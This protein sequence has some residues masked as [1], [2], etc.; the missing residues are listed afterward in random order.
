MR[1][2]SKKIALLLALVMLAAVIPTAMADDGN[3]GI[4]PAS[5]QPL[6]EVGTYNDPIVIDLTDLNPDALDQVPMKT[7]LEK[8]NE[9][10]EKESKD[11]VDTENSTVAWTKCYYQYN[12]NGKDDYKL[13]D[14]EGNL[15]LDV[16]YTVYELEWPD[17]DYAVTEDD[18]ADLR[19]FYTNDPA[20]VYLLLIVG[21]K[22]NDQL[23]AESKRF[24]VKALLPQEN[25]ILDFTATN[26]DDGANN[27]PIKIIDVYSH[28][29]YYDKDTD[30]D[31][32]HVEIPLSFKGESVSLKMDFKASLEDKYKDLEIYPGIFKTKEEAASAVKLDDNIYTDKFDG[33]WYTKEYTAFYKDGNGIDRVYHFSVYLSTSGIFVYYDYLMDKSNNKIY[34]A[35]YNKGVYTFELRNGMEVNDEYSLVMRA[36]DDEYPARSSAENI[37]AAYEGLYISQEEALEDGKENIKDQLF[38]IGYKSN[39]FEAG[40]QF[41]IIDNNDQIVRYKFTVAPYVAPEPTEPVPSDD[42]SFSITGVKKTA[43]GDLYQTFASEYTYNK[44]TDDMKDIYQTVFILESEEKIKE[45]ADGN[46][47]PQWSADSDA[48]VAW[49]DIDGGAAAEK[50]S[51]SSPLKFTPGEPVHITVTAEDGKHVTNYYV[52]FVAQK[53]EAELYVVGENVHDSNY[54]DQLKMPGRVVH[55]GDLERRETYYD[56]MFANIGNA[57]LS[58]V[59]VSWEGEPQNVAIDEYWTVT[60]G[61]TL[62]AFDSVDDGSSLKYG[63]LGNIGKV[64]LVPT[65]DEDGKIN[66]GTIRGIL[67]I[68]AGEKEVKI[69]ISGI[70]GTP[71]ITT[72]TLDDQDAVKYVPY[73]VILQS[74][75]VSSKTV[76]FEISPFGALPPMGI[77]LAQGGALY[78]VTTAMPRDYVFTVDLVYYENGNRYILDEKTYTLTVRENTDELVWGE[79]DENYDVIQYVGRQSGDY[80]FVLSSVGDQVFSSKGAFG[81]FAAF[82]LDGKMLTE[83]EDYKAEEGSTIITIFEET[84]RSTNDGKSHTIAAEFRSD[85]TAAGEEP[86]QEIKRAAQ[87]YTVSLSTSGTIPP[88][89]TVVTK[90]DEDEQTSP[91]Q[92]TE[93]DDDSPK[94]FPFTDVK[95][96]DWEYEEV[97]WAYEKELMLGVSDTRFDSESPVSQAIIVTVLARM[98]GVDLSKYDGVTYPGVPEGMWYTNAAIWAKQAGLLPDVEFTETAP[99]GRDRMAIMLVKYLQSMGIDVSEPAVPYEFKDASEMTEAANAAF[100]ALYKL[101]IFKGVG[102]MHMAPTSNTKRCEFATLIHRISNLIEE[103]K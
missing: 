62:G 51:G 5:L 72:E 1:K 100:Q 99:T 81:E 39:K 3:G 79:T 97:K 4:M 49:A 56:I 11:Q 29:D 47:Y 77:E 76:S 74:D 27:A 89:P 80:H 18:I 59:T 19:S 44:R 94:Q 23:N 67:K 65:Y 90:P 16:G 66:H 84:I 87:N 48:K 73:G 37:K 30:I 12:L 24:V 40:V 28:L 15:D 92:P 32:Y 101:G 70:A 45:N 83:G 103:A 2:I 46:I 78:G 98:Q 60:Q 25:K 57:E 50:T 71:K 58:G 54:D 22:A 35:S 95:E 61:A 86:K 8:L 68:A 85:G 102:D 31:V 69:K 26:A 21:E 7:V 13:P 88:P 42:T 41:T 53:S 93:P 9:A 14:A 52:T 34:S 43:E 96:S 63:V 75:N 55:L 64:R 82:Y 36:R 17:F 33:Y 91:S 20:C 6:K 38:G 10:L